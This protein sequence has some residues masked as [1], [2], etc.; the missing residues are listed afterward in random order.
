MQPTEQRLADLEKKVDAMTVIVNK[1]YKVFLATVIISIIA[2]VLPL[3]GLLFAI[4]S[5]MAN[6]ASV[7]GQ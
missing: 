2:F 5:F 3:I 4:P 1:L 6:Y 7:L